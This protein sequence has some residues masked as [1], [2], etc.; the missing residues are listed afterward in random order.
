MESQLHLASSQPTS[1]YEL[2]LKEKYTDQIVHQNHVLDV[3]AKYLV[4]LE[5]LVPVSYLFVLNY[6]S[7]NVGHVEISLL[8][9]LGLSAWFS[10][11]L[12]SLMSL[13]GVYHPKEFDSVKALAEPVS[14][15]S[16]ESYLKHCIAYKRKKL[17]GASILFFGGTVVLMFSL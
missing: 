9:L 11:L 8:M 12:L 6:H 4:V 13:S 3:L 5:L 17:M 10:A 16:V 2:R 7:L 14:R 1:L 15:V